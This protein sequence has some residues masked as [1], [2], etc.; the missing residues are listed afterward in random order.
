MTT[1]VLFQNPW[2]ITLMVLWILPWKGIALWRSARLNQK[3]WFIALLVTNTMA[4]LEILYIFVFSKR[5]S[6][7]GSRVSDTPSPE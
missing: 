4:I 3:W 7:R 5:A 1:E 6:F 2:I